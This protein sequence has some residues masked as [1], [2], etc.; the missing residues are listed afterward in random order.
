MKHESE[1]ELKAAA[2]R[3]AK[4]EGARKRLDQARAILAKVNKH[5]GA[6]KTWTVQLELEPATSYDPYSR[7]TLR[8][9]IHGAH[10]QQRAVDD[11]RRIERELIELGAVP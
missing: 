1:A 8:Y 10:I 11:V 3:L 5:V 4:I 2:A 9:K 6:G 7:V